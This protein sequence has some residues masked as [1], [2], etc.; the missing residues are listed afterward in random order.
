MITVPGSLGTHCRVY[1]V[2]Q[3]TELGL[4]KAPY[5]Y[6]V[7]LPIT[8]AQGPFPSR[9]PSFRGW[10]HQPYPSNHAISR[11]IN[12]SRARKLHEAR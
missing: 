4:V 3:V 9:A 1:I 2:D 7:S 12:N 8:A 10:K 6:L 11:H 5:L